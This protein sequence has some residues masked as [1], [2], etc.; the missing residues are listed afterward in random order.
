MVNGCSYNIALYNFNL[1]HPFTI[2]CTMMV[3]TYNARGWSDHREQ[4]PI[5]NFAKGHFKGGAGAPTAD[6]DI[7]EKPALSPETLQEISNMFSLPTCQLQ[8]FDQWSYT[9]NYDAVH[10]SPVLVLYTN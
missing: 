2:I 9:S 4:F 5:Q 6:P 1:I 7:V 8:Q 10:T 3:L